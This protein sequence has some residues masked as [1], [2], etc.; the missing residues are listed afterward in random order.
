M[1]GRIIQAIETSGSKNPVI[2]LDEIDKMMRSHMGDPTAAMLEVL[3]PEQNINFTDHYIDIPFDLSDVFFIATANSLDS[4]YKAL[5]DRLEVIRLSGYTL[6][7][8]L[9]IARY[10]LVPKQLPIHGFNK[11]KLKISDLAIKR[12]IQEYTKEAGVRNLERSI[13]KICR[14]AATEIVRKEE[15]KIS[16]SNK[17]LEK[18]L[19]IPKYTT[20]DKR[21]INEVGVINGLAWTEI[22]GSILYIE[23]NLMPGK[24]KLNLTGSLGDV[25]QESAN[26]ALSF[27]RSNYEKYS[28]PEK[29][30]EKYDVHVHVPDGATP[31]DGPSAGLAITLS[32]ISSFTN[33]PIKADV[34]LTGEVTLRGKV[35]PIGGLKEKVLAAI[36]NDIH[37]IIIP[38]KNR[39]DVSD[40]PDYVNNQ[41]KYIYV[42]DVDQAMKYVFD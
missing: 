13:A 14:K 11:S 28:I 5:R 20:E 39:K 16:I 38:E 7:E 9:N 31:K 29:L 3:D 18:Y 15:S 32:M 24:G 21:V 2:L 10:F 17:N 34:A 8:K 23:S 33:K 4:V 27:I 25:M 1:P 40:L 37:T 6:E 12:I 35:L 22:G 36:R 41:V 26:L 30:E 19:G 42:N